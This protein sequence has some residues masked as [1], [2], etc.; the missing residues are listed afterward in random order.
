M[1]TDITSFI[2]EGMAQ[3]T[4]TLLVASHG[5]G[6]GRRSWSQVPIPAVL[7]GH[8]SWGR[9]ARISLRRHDDGIKRRAGFVVDFSSVPRDTHGKFKTEEEFFQVQIMEPPVSLRDG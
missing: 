9:L 4:Q 7:K 1:G 3:N 6:H 2:E 5:H 8:R